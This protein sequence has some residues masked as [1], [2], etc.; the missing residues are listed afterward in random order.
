MHYFIEK[1]ICSEVVPFIIK[2]TEWMYWFTLYLIPLVS[3][4]WQCC[5]FLY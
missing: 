4:T 3:R 5:Y 2:H 1:L